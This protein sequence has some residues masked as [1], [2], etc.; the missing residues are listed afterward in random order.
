MLDQAPPHGTDLQLANFA[1]LT[2]FGTE[3]TPVQ[4]EAALALI[5][6]SPMIRTAW[7]ERHEAFEDELRRLGKAAS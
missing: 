6:A 5:Q 4:R 2:C 7:L 1:A 3:P